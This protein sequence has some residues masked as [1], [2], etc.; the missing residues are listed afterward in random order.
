MQRTILTIWMIGILASSAVFGGNV[1]HEA[2][3][4][5]DPDDYHIVQQ[6]ATIEIK[7]PVAGTFRFYATDDTDPDNLGVINSITVSSG[8]S[9]T[10]T[11][12]VMVWGEENDEYGARHVGE[13]YLSTVSQTTT[14]FD[15]RT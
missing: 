2:N 10:G 8:W 4:W 7:R 13:I 6:Y 3:G 9:G 12:R 15:F 11:I 5:N 14:Q 1:I